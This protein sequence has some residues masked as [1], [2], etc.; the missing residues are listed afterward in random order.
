MGDAYQDFDIEDNDPPIQPWSSQAVY[1]KGISS[2]VL[3]T[4]SKEINAIKSE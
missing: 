2:E 4:N 1:H 3:N